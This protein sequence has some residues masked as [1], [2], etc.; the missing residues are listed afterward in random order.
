MVEQVIQSMLECARQKLLLQIHRNESRAG[1]DVFVACH[2]LLQIIAPSL[3]LI[4][5]LVRGTMRLRL[6]FCYS[7]VRHLW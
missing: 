5:D 2:L 1:V 3:T 4:F 6:N 7:F